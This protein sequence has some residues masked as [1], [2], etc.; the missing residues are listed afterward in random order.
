[1]L[2][3]ARH[4]DE[5]LQPY[6]LEPAPA[7]AATAVIHHTSPTLRYHRAATVDLHVRFSSTPQLSF[8]L[9]IRPV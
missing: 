4:E 5:Y 2:Q 6:D 1:M 9:S 3:T 7:A 8:Q